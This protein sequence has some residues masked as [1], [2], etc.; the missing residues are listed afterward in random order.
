MP[1]EKVDLSFGINPTREITRGARAGQLAPQFRVRLPGW[2]D[3]L[4]VIPESALSADERAARQRER[5]FLLRDSPVPGVVGDFARIGQEIDNVQDA[6]VTLSVG[7]RVA[8]KLAGRAIPGVGWVATAA[9]VLNVL[10][11]FYPNNVAGGV[12]A[13]TRVAESARGVGGKYVLSKEAKRQMGVVFTGQGGTYRQRLAETLQTGKIG[14]GW[15][16]GLQILQTTDQLFGVGLQLGPIFGAMT[17]TF[18]GALR[19]AEFDVTAP[20]KATFD[21]LEWTGIPDSIRKWIPLSPLT[22]VGGLYGNIVNTLVGQVFG[23]RPVSGPAQP[24]PRITVELPGVLPLFDNLLGLEPGT[25][26]AD[27]TRELAPLIGPAQ[28]AERAVLAG[29]GYFYKGLVGASLG[30]LRGTQYLWGLRDDLT[31]ENHVELALTHW[32]ALKQLRPL[33][34]SFEWGDAAAVAARQ[35]WPYGSVPGLDQ[36]ERRCI[37]D[38]TS[39]LRD[40]TAALPQKW[41]DAQPDPD[42]RGFAHEVV[43]GYVDELLPSL[44][45][46]DARVVED[47]GPLARGVTA[48]HEFDLL[49]PVDSS[50]AERLQYIEGMAQLV[51]PVGEGY[52]SPGDA[53]ELY[54]SVFR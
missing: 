35:P 48:M 53:L 14:F 30:I 6:L 51:G 44:E 8:T 3:I 5:F 42:L 11:A 4:H 38:V 2:E 27:I 7:G 32:L 43:R 47:G 9:D 12:K 18:F 37:G 31:W 50:D 20:Y 52:G 22:V 26:E 19:G 54:R 28:A 16:E 21:P 13:A 10:N 23:E 29:F 34:Q 24:T 39:E 49:P 41:I 33:L 46:D 15:G 25:M 45:G 1:V 36:A 17:D 40:R